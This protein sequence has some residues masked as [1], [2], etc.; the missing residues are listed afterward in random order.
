MHSHYVLLD[1]HLF[2]NFMP[3]KEREK[4]SKGREATPQVM[5]NRSA[6]EERERR[7][8]G[9]GKW[10]EV[11]LRGEEKR[12]LGFREYYLVSVDNDTSASYLRP[13]SIINPTHQSRYPDP[14]VATAD[15]DVSLSCWLDIM[16]SSSLSQGGSEKRDCLRLGIS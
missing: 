11:R 14:T 8:E 5:E 1:D 6:I 16:V 13:S 3:K 12:I 10:G 9:Q 2:K 15:R 7:R 4:E